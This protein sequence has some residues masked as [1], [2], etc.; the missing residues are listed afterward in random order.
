MASDT[1]SKACPDRFSC[2]RA[3]RTI[4]RVPQQS[5]SIT[6]SADPSGGRRGGR[7]EDMGGFRSGGIG[8]PGRTGRELPFWAV[9]LFIAILGV[10]PACGTAHSQGPGRNASQ[11]TPDS[12]DD[13]ERSL[14]N[15]AAHV[16]ERQWSEAID[17]YQRV[18]DRYGDKVAKLPKNGPG[19]DPSGEFTLYVDDRGFC[20]RSLAQ[21]P[22]EARA[23]YRHRVER[24]GR[25]LVSSGSH[26]SGCQSAP[27]GRR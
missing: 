21:L 23:I 15:A 4:A 14:R 9:S 8:R 10:L 6:G 16:Q 5:V 7:G 20:H 18:I 13:A 3:N 27:Q 17:I 12:S 1:G 19:G 24:A 25:A 2:C 11:F 22:P 26:S